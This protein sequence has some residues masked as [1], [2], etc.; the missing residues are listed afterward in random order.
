MSR[1]SCVSVLVFRVWSKQAG[2]RL[3]C[4][5]DSGLVPGPA[6]HG[7]SPSPWKKLQ[8]CDC[9]ALLHGEAWKVQSSLPGHQGVLNAELSGAILECEASLGKGHVLHCGR[10]SPAPT[11]LSDCPLSHVN[12]SSAPWGSRMVEDM[13]QGLYFTLATSSP[14][15]SNHP[16]DLVSP[17]L[18]RAS[19]A[20]SLGDFVI[21]EHGGSGPGSQGAAAHSNLTVL[22]RGRIPGSKYVISSGGGDMSL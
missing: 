20:S 13:V 22:L 4:R 15:F 12:L 1:V 8:L 21:L 7:V 9:H 5:R 3:S 11:G 16:L 10:L 2:I 19:S 18:P 14:V 6:P 17:D